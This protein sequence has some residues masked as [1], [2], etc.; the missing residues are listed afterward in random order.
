MLVDDD[1][2]V[3]DVVSGTVDVE[4]EVDDVD[5]VASVVVGAIVVG[6]TVVG[7]TVV[8][9]VVGTTFRV[10]IAVAVATSDCVPI[11][12]CP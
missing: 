4:D 7:A 6:G 5:V 1:D 9:V 11:P 12:N 8:V 10:A 3:V 2:D